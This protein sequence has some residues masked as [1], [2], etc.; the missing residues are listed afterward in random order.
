MP[1]YLKELGYDLQL[2]RDLIEQSQERFK[3]LPKEE[4]QKIL[5]MREERRK[6]KQIDIYV[7][8][9]I[10]P[11]CGGKLIRGEKDKNNGYKRHWD[12]SKCSIRFDL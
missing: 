11:E 1:D 12:C 6:I 4:Q 5:V 2:V 10:C 3:L 9:G 7:H 8:R